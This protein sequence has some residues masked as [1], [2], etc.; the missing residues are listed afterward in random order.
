[1][2][3]V[4]VD[5]N[6]CSVGIQ[7]ILRAPKDTADSKILRVLDTMGA[8]AVE[9]CDDHIEATILLRYFDDDKRN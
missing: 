9:C 2:G 3:D 1:M 8:A 7:L 4:S 5:V 6:I